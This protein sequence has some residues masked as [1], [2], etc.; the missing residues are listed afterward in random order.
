M[1][2][3]RKAGHQPTHLHPPLRRHY[4]RDALVWHEVETPEGFLREPIGKR[5][6]ERL[7][8]NQVEIFEKPFHRNQ[9]FKPCKKNNE[10]NVERKKPQKSTL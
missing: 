9:C 4:C 6:E 3:T 8:R 1:N 2:A 5:D 10:A 7:A